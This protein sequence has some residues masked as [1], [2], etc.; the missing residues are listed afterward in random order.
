SPSEQPGLFPLSGLLYQNESTLGMMQHSWSMSADSI[1]T[2]RFGFLRNVAVGGNEASGL[3][4]I[5]NQ[6]GI[7]NTFDNRG[8]STA[9]LQGYSSFGRANGDI[10]N[11][12]NT[13]QLDE[14]FTYNN[15]GHILTAGVGLRSRRGWHANGNATALGALSF[16]PV[17]TAQLAASSQG[18]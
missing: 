13:W 18:Q 10:G 5:L 12:D 14:E 6:I 7:T 4:P 3:G 11:R 17:F 1:N 2:L 9:N 8:V 15:G 16:Q